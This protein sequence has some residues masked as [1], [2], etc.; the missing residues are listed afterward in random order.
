MP[1]GVSVSDIPGYDEPPMYPDIR[2]ACCGCFIGYTGIK[3][4]VGQEVHYR[5]FQCA[6]GDHATC[7]NWHDCKEP[8]EWK[9]YEG[10]TNWYQCKYCGAATPVNE[11]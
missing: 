3:Q 2:C 4:P 11:I 5:T 7:D 1:P 6:G 10:L 9:D 8:H